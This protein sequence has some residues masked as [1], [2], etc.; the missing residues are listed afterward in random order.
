VVDE[1]DTLFETGKLSSIM[2][3]LLLT[4]K[5]SQANT[6]LEIIL[7]GT[8]RSHELI[9]YLKDNLGEITELVDKNTHLNL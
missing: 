3:N 6:L 5:K 4:A 1:A 7:S 9:K 2:D 8:T